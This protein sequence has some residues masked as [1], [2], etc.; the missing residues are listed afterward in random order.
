[1]VVGG[2][3]SDKPMS[4]GMPGAPA[5]A[6]L[7]AAIP[8][9]PA[10][11]VNFGGP[12][13]GGE[14]PL[15]AMPSAPQEMSRGTGNLGGMQATRSATPMAGGPGL[16]GPPGARLPATAGTPNNSAMPAIQQAGG[17]APSLGPPVPSPGSGQGS[18]NSGGSDVQA[19]G[20]SAQPTG[21]TV[22]A[23][24]HSPTPLP[25]SASPGSQSPSRSDGTQESSATS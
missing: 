5:S 14:A 8:G 17:G 15:S 7:G 4:P 13:G 1:P 12:G 2:S 22:G 20:S 3:A 11:G 6:T 9:G 16:G 24:P 10:R 23:A 19:R 21:E 25:A 18:A